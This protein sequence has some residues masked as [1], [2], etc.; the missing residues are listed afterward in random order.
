MIFKRQ[1]GCAFRLDDYV[2]LSAISEVELEADQGS[3]ATHTMLKGTFAV[4]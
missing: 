3:L 2:S 1:Q 4:A